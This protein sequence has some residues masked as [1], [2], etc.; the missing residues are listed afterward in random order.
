V[1]VVEAAPEGSRHVE[2]LHW[3]KRIAQLDPHDDAAEIYRILVSHEFPWDMNQALSFA[4]FRTYAVPSIGSLLHRTGEFTERTQKRYEDTGLLLDAVVEHGLDSP[5]GK[6]AVRRINQMHSAY[7]ISNDD[8][9]Y[10]LCTFVAVP[11]RWMD[12]YGW[13]RFTEAEKVA[14][15]N[16]YRDLG[17][18]MAIRDIP[19]TWQDFTATMDAYEATSFGYDDG[20]RVVAEATLALLADLPPNDKLPSVL[21]RQMS[22]ALMDEPLLDAFRFPHPR[23]VVR[24]VVQAGLKARA[25]VVRRM[26]PRQQPRFLRDLPSIRLYAGGY[27]VAQLGTYPRGCPAGRSDPA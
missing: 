18:H 11:I 14:S 25:Q 20:A 5:L 27:D 2:R 6:T 22:F 13:R 8:M 21:V 7:D 4:L 1:A 15:A 12:A 9:R 26:P 23:P 3:A 19:E 10:V 17:R 16:Y 24:R